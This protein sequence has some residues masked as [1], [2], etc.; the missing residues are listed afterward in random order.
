M[1]DFSHETSSE[2]STAV[3]VLCH[4]G[5]FPPSLVHEGEDKTKWTVSYQSGCLVYKHASYSIS[6]GLFKLVFASLFVQHESSFLLVLFLNNP[7]HS[8]LSGF[9]EYLAHPRIPI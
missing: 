1:L 5:A 9:I 2:L 7:V 8:C 3:S 6:S 4:V